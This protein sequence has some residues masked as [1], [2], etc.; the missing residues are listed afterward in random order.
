MKIWSIIS[1][2]FFLGSSTLYG[3]GTCA[4]AIALTP[5]T[6]QCGTNSSAGSF[7]DGGGAPS[8]PCSGLYNDGEYWF[9]FTGTGNSLQLDVSSL[10]DTYSGLF[11]LDDCPTASPNCVASY[12]SG[13]STADFTVNTPA[14]TAGQT[15]YI[16]IANWSSPYDT[17]FCLDAT[18]VLPS[19]GMDC[20][21]ALTLT[22]GT[23]QCGT[24]NF[25]G[26]FADGGGAPSN[27][28]SGSYNDGEFWF[29][30]TAT[31]DALE[32]DVSGLTDTYSG[33]FV[34]D[35]CPG[36]SPNCIASYTSGSS[37]ADFT[38]NTP[39]LTAGQTYYIVIANFGAPY[40]TDFCLDATEV[41]PA[42][43]MDCGSALT[44]TPGTTQCATNNF[45][46]SFAD[47]GGA[48]SNP[49][50]GSYNDGEFWFEYTATGD[51]LELDVSGLTDT[52]SG[53]F[54]L[55]ACPS[56]SPNCIASY[57]SGSSTADFTVN[58]P[59]LTAGQ[60]Y[61]IVISNFGAPYSTDFCLDATEVPPTPGM[62]CSSAIPLTP[63]T[64]QCA[65][66][67]FVG[68]FPDNGG[69]P[70]NPCSGSYNDG[71][72]WFEY[73]GTGDQLVL[74]VSSLTNTYS[75]LFVLNDC[76]TNSPGCIASYTSGS[77]S[78]DFTVTTPPLTAGQTYYIVIS[79]FGAPYSTDFCLDAIEQVP[80]PATEQECL[81]GTTVCDDSQI[82]GNSS[83]SGVFQEL[84]G[85]NSG[86]MS[87]EHESSWYLFSAET[88]GSIE[89]T[90]S[91]VNGTDDYDFAIWGPY[92]A[93]STAASMCPPS[94]S[95]LLCSFSAIDGDT[96]LQNGA[97]DNTEGA[98]GD[99]WVENI[100]ANAGD[101]YILLIDNFSS[102]TSPFD[103]NWNLTNGASLDCTV[104]PVLLSDFSGLHLADQRAN[105][106][107]WTTKSEV[108][109]HHFR[110]EKSTDGK[111]FEFLEEI[112]S[113]GDNSWDNNY[114][115]LDKKIT[116]ILTYYRLVQ[117]DLDGKETVY[118]TISISS[119][120]S[121]LIYPNPSQSELNISLGNSSF[122]YLNVEFIDMEG[123]TISEKVTN[124][125]ST[126][127]STVFKTL[128]NGIYFVRIT[129][130]LGQ[131]IHTEKVVK[132]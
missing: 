39:S 121:I 72:F 25:S 68:S 105:Q 56:S 75:G 63:G 54:V 5:G 119:E 6:T 40:S 12:T 21:S 122:E 97:G 9:E 95:P 120:E 67:S 59:S 23:T 123:K 36:S 60:T 31:G 7:P 126:H 96:G 2:F 92:P 108:N 76:P 53:L 57:T 89:F 65:T 66:N 106:I 34:L 86:C 46:G 102:T 47:G 94:S 61:Y 132:F 13:S 15:Y 37:T 83:G 30:Y 109:C 82:S 79:N 50:S 112:E 33:L 10:T 118:G 84:D 24:N 22:P 115:F 131:I 38:V 49:C 28:C 87:T 14:L 128:A 69:A 27:P 130:P 55:D 116:S 43:G 98:G 114:E 77:S 17:D 124:N 20:G 101:T 35:A 16:V 73:T 32:L 26:S 127:T 8:N 11:V 99:A 81:G 74:D 78:A 91:P 117:V 129:N 100:D 52:Y 113:M 41:L 19:P 62:D 90:L 29:E 88:G 44:L 125:N 85:T 107:N 45:T 1:L 103:L 93:G 42:P 111:N 48:P 3:Q 4:G 18:E 80:P 110:L 70:S 58:T 64:T 71:E 51:A 104:L